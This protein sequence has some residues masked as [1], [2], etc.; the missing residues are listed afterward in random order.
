MVRTA[1][2]TVASLLAFAANS[3]LARAALGD[4][5]IDPASFTAIRLASGAAA[6]TLVVWLTSQRSAKRASAGSWLSALA[7]FAYAIAFSWAYLSLDAGTGALVLFGA[8]QATMIGAGLWMGERPGAGRWIGLALSLG[9]LVYLV[10]PGLT[11]PDPLGAALMAASGACWGIYSLRGRS[12]GR[13]VLATTGNFVRTVPPVLV[14]L[15][16]TAIAGTGTGA[17][18]G[19]EITPRGLALALVSG[20]VT[21]GLGYVV[22][23]AALAGLSATVAAIVQLAVPVIAA[24]GGVLLLD[25]EPTARLAL[26]SLLILGGVAIATLSGDRVKC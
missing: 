7:L 10:L 26:A 3:L 22:W 18:A 12:D 4:A 17:G 6:L 8:V 2:A 24:L 11:A 23:Y 1:V 5:A 25:E 9:G 13:P 21:S 16:A 20:V 14:L 19:L 15:A